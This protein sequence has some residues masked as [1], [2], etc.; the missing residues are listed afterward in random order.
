M[1]ETGTMA[2]RIVSIIGKDSLRDV[3]RKVQLH[4]GSA[5]HM[6]VQKWTKGGD[7]EESNLV[8]FCAAYGTT[9]A[10][11]RYGIGERAALSERQLAAAELIDN[12]P[13]EFVQQGLDFMRY[14]LVRSPLMGDPE[15]TAR[16]LKLLDTL[17]GAKKQ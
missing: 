9:P 14:Q 13:P 12:S 1:Q 8:A 10:Y 16:Y 2:S 15:R 17:V 4:G 6:A 7:I 11:V 3:A 5:S